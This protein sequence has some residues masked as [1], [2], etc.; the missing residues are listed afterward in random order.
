MHTRLQ[1]SL[2]DAVPIAG[3]LFK[4]SDPMSP[5]LSVSAPPY[6]GHMHARRPCDTAA[7][8]CPNSEPVLSRDRPYMGPLGA[9]VL[10]NRMGS[11]A[12]LRPRMRRSCLQAVCLM[13]SRRQ[14]HW[15][16][17]RERC[18]RDLRIA[19]A[20]G[21]AAAYAI[22][23]AFFRHRKKVSS[24]LKRAGKRRS[25]QGQ[26]PAGGFEGPRRRVDER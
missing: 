5:S 2:R 9:I 7:K 15:G 20:R 13:C 25:R 3:Q 18:A 23:A 16:S 24:R 14:G 1:T 19:R 21:D 4:G 12:S 17:Y 22:Q 8:S 11:T 26:D 6:T 10:G